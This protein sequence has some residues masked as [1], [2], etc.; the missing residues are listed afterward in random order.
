MSSTLT[1]SELVK[2]LRDL[3]PGV[4]IKGFGSSV[5]EF[6]ETP[7]DLVYP[8]GYHYGCYINKFKIKNNLRI[9]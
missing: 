5:I 1:S 3:N 4:L 2:R 9:T 6:S 8:K 7:K